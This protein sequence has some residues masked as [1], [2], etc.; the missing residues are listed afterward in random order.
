MVTQ[1]PLLFWAT[2]TRMKGGERCALNFQE[3]PLRWMEEWDCEVVGAA[4]GEWRP[5]DSSF[6]FP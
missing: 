3:D 6:C 4:A 1:L 5:K 2:C